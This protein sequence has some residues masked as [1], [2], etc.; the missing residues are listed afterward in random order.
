MSDI[1]ERPA[2]NRVVRV[3]SR[4][5]I[6]RSVV[7]DDFHH[8]RVEITHADGRVTGTRSE[9]ARFPYSLCPAA[10]SRLDDLIG[11]ALTPRISDLTAAIDARLQCT[12]QFD[13]ATL[14]IAAAARGTI[15]RRYDVIVEDSPDGARRAV[16]RRDGLPLLDWTIDGRTIV[17]PRHLAGVGIGNGF[18]ARTALMPD[19]DEAEAALVLRRAV[20]VSGGR[21]RTEQ[22]DASSHAPPRAGCWVQQ[23]ARAP[24]ARRMRSSTQDFTGRRDM[25][26]QDDDAWIAFADDISTR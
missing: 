3:A 1:V 9:A 8:F 24:E 7:E 15:T 6:A 21:G 2:L 12:H 13:I 10:G 23:P 18:T 17:S 25:L 4:P 26:T 19:A 22:L 16:L 20:F 5:G 11:R 14:A